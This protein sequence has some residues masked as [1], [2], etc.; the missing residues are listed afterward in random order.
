MGMLAAGAYLRL[1]REGRGLTRASLAR[2]LS[3]DDTQV[4]RI[5]KGRIDTRS[6]LLFA[7]IREVRGSADQVMLLLLDDAAG[8]E[9]GR[10][11]AE[12]WLEPGDAAAGED[13]RRRRALALID[14]LLADPQKLD[15]LLGYGDRLREER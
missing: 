14:D 1:L 8:E 9:Q 13:V 5:E 10:A 15:R 6:S 4:E 3:T 7:F 12:A 2:Q 11:L